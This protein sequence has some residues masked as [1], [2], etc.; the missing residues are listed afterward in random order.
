MS[1]PNGIRRKANL[2]TAAPS[3]GGN[4]ES[5]K[6]GRTHHNRKKEIPEKTNQKWMLRLFVLA[7]WLYPLRFLLKGEQIP[8]MF[9]V[10][11]IVALLYTIVYFTLRSFLNNELTVKRLMS[12]CFSVVLGS[13]PIYVL[14]FD[15]AFQDATILIGRSTPSVETAL[16]LL[17][18]FYCGDMFWITPSQLNIP[19]LLVHHISV[20]V[21]WIWSQSQPVALTISM[22]AQLQEI[23]N[24]F[25]YFHW[26]AFSSYAYKD[27]TKRPWF[28]VNAF[29]IFFG[30]LGLRLFW[31]QLRT[32]QY[33]W[34]MVWNYPIDAAFMVPTGIII[35]TVINM[36][37]IYKLSRSILTAWNTPVEKIR[38]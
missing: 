17:L 26:I 8:L 32:T 33:I 27:Q 2:S 34:W 12:G 29:L 22:L 13:V 4:E 16:G 1:S 28:F 25:W 11:Y 24:P 20:V 18:G 21:F 15:P 30:Y 38:D 19:S 23:C 31:V 7:T 14:Y 6:N 36:M 9:N 35:E 10:A 3:A 37:N 5:G